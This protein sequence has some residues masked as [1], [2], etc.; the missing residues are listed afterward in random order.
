MIISDSGEQSDWFDAAKIGDIV[1][2]TMYR[3]VWTHSHR[4]FWFSINI[5]FFRPIDL[6]AYG[7]DNSKSFWQKC[8]LY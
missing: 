5:Y 1:G 8:N 7:P 3:N 2:I 4:H 6:H